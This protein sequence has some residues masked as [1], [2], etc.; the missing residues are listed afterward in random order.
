[1]ATQT[2]HSARRTVAARGVGFT[3]VE[4]LVVIAI[5][6]LLVGILAPSLQQ[7]KVFAR[8]GKVA[9]LIKVLSTGL[10]QFNSDP[11]VGDEFP[12]SIWNT[13]GSPG[14]NPYTAS[15]QANPATIGRPTTGDEPYIAYG[16]QTLIWALAGADMLGPPGFKKTLSGTDGLYV[17]DGARPRYP[18]CSPFVDITKLDVRD[19]LEGKDI[20]TTGAAAT[21]KAKANIPVI[22]DDFD[23]PILYFRADTTKL[24]MDRY[25]YT[26]NAPF[27]NPCPPSGWNEANHSTLDWIA[28]PSERQNRDG[29]P[30]YPNGFALFVHNY[31][32][33]T[34]IQPFN[35]DSFLLISAGPDGYYGTRDDIC[36]FPVDLA[37]IPAGY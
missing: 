3:L 8:Q 18:R 9:A 20:F 31:K 37:N 33:R 5:I 7:A 24:N 12:P 10:E 21:Y 2:K 22:M 17:L 15:G 11:T 14:G 27:C 32:V 26:D 6:A 35:Y 36:N 16:A 28:C 19:P 25:N 34:V 1:M 29:T 13:A 4:L 23:N 30:T